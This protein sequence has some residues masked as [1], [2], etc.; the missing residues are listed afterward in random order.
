MIFGLLKKGVLRQ[1]KAGPADRRRRRG[2]SS[3]R[4]RSRRAT[5]RAAFYREAAINQRRARFTPTSIRFCPPAK[6]S[7][8]PVREVDFGLPMKMLIASTAVRMK[9]FDLS[10]TKDYYRSIVRR[11]TQQA[12]AIGDIPQ[13]ER[14]IDRNFEWIL[15]DDGFPT[16][17]G[18]GPY[19][20]IWTRGSMVGPAAGTGAE[21][22][23]RHSRHDD[24]WR[25]GLRFRRFGRRTRWETSRPRFTPGSLNLP[26]PSGGFLDLSGAITSPASSSRPSATPP[27]AA[28]ARWRWRRMRVRRLRM[29]CA[30]AGG[31]R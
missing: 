30:C 11:A 21:R 4:I 15:M 25:R 31:G 14:A 3:A 27:P 20:P 9:G 26:H 18:H 2:L 8:K 5:A 17:F 7:R 16:V 22:R 24:V 6:Q 13:R 1:V 29:R 23:R 19:R 28:V 10:D 12:A